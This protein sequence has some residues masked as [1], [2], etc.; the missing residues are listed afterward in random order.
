MRM[1]SSMGWRCAFALICASLISLPSA[2]WA[3][4]LPPPPEAEAKP[5]PPSEVSLAP[6]SPQPPTPL[7]VTISGGGTLGAYMGGELYYMG[8]SNRLAQSTYEPRVFTGASAGSI[9]AFISVMT[10]CA[11]IEPSPTESMFWK[12]W[13]PSGI[14]EFFR[15][16]QKGG[17][18]LLTPKGFD[19]GIAHLKE[20]WEAGLPKDCD[21]LL[22]IAITRAKPLEITLA[23]GFPAIPRSLETVTLRVTGRGKGRPPKLSNVVDPSRVTPQLLLPL[24]GRHADPFLSLK[25]LA[26]ASSAFPM[27]F[28]PVLVRH[29]LRGPDELAQCTAGEAEEALF[30]DGGVFDNQPLGLAVRA[31]RGVHVKDGRLAIA[32]HP[33]PSLPKSAQFY[34]L[35]PRVKGYPGLPADKQEPVVGDVLGVVASMFSM[36]DSVR[37]SELISIFDST[38]ELRDR[39]L[40]GRTFFPPA[41]GTFTGFLD[42]SL[43]EFDFYLGMYDAARTIREHPAPHKPHP[44]E[45]AL[46]HGTDADDPVR[47][48]WQRF[49]CLRA[50]LDG[51]GD[52]QSCAGDDLRDFRILLQLSLDRLTDTCARLRKEKEV[53]TKH[54]QCQ[55]VI[56]GGA[57]PRVPGVRDLADAKRLRRAGEGHLAYQLRLLGHYGFHFRDLGLRRSQS[58][59]AKAQLIRLGHRMVRKLSETQPRNGLLVGVLG[60]VGVDTA[61]GY[62]P[63]EHILHLV[64]GLGAEGGYSSTTPLGLPW[65]RFGVALGLDG[66]ST[67]LNENDN[68]LALIPKAGIEVELFGGSR[69]QLRLGARAGFQFSTAD[70]L[71]SGACDFAREKVA[72]CSRFVTEGYLSATVLGLLRLQVAAN[73]APGLETG[74]KRLYALNPMLGIQINSPF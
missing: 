37:S 48:S 68:Y 31:M 57:A 64:F 28:P 22:G 17:T 44:P 13:I 46:V 42:R 56:N 38:P 47:K 7:A 62:L 43:R 66:F 25:Q 45:E 24:D 63:P 51:K 59:Q 58:T 67:L 26:L 52:P 69:L 65:L 15:S 30:I 32:K 41:S 72:P 3:Q 2:P 33:A 34:F 16:D 40:L 70:S 53:A 1:Q 4:E 29:C 19:A 49:F 73:Y 8:L 54:R 20:A 61:L 18:S 21:L 60:R 39:L 23:P 55:S 50:V 11:E 71:A 12:V 10:T 35:D 6:P 14:R 36:I 27:G 9:N 74:Q 5:A